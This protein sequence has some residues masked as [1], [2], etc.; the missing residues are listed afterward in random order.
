MTIA[1]FENG[2]GNFTDQDLVDFDTYYEFEISKSGTDNQTALSF[3]I[4]SRTGGNNGTLGVNGNISF[5]GRI[6][7]NYYNISLD[8]DDLNFF[9]ATVYKHSEVG[10]YKVKIRKGTGADFRIAVVQ[11]MKISLK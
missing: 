6:N 2:N 4:G 10:A 9:P 7:N 8:I 5:Y 11:G 3:F 1:D